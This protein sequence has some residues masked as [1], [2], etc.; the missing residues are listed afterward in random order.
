MIRISNNELEKFDFYFTADTHFGS[1][2][3][4]GLSQ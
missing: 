1:V 2:I 3:T 4:Y